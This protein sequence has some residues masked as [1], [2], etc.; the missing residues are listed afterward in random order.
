MGGQ[1]TATGNTHNTTLRRDQSQQRRQSQVKF[2]FLKRWGDALVPAKGDTYLH[3]DRR[4][5]LHVCGQQYHPVLVSS[6]DPRRG[7]P[8]VVWKHDARSRPRK[9]AHSIALLWHT[10]STTETSE[11]NGERRCLVAARQENFSASGVETSKRNIPDAPNQCSRVGVRSRS[12]QITSDP[13]RE[14]NE[15]VAAL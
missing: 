2:M 13:S 7:K 4:G 6:N 10:I 3:A 15:T 14:K 1:L 9:S 8:K 11:Q 12:R 5:R